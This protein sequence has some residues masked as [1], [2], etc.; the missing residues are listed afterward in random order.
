ML[1]HACISPWWSPGKGKAKPRGEA[2]SSLTY[3]IDAF[4]P[5]EAQLSNL[6]GDHMEL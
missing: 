4:G 6:G 1:F 5:V 3:H 2:A